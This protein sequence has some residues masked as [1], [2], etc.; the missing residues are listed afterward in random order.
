MQISVGEKVHVTNFKESHQN[1]TKLL[2]TSANN[3]TDLSV[4][5]LIYGIL[6]LWEVTN[7]FITLANI[8]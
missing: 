6:L 1:Y 8:L 3:A 4:D 2:N 5:Q 7:K